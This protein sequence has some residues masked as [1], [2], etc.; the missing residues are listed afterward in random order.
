MIRLH[1]APQTRSMRTLWLLHELGL[2]FEVVERPFDK[3]LRAPDYLALS[4]AGRV[5]SLE[6]DGEILFETGAIA[7]Y[8]CERF[9]EAGLGVAPGDEGRAD[10]LIWL[11]FAE[12]LS[13]H[14]AA[15][16][17]QHIMLYE[18]A[19]RSPVVMKLE[20]ARLGKCY[21]ALEAR[22][23]GR[24]HLAAGRATA[25]DIGVAQA[26]YMAR[27]FA[28]I[29]DFPRLAAWYARMTARPAFAASLPGEG[30]RLYAKDFY[31]AWEG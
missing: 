26:I 10:W 27:H 30:A 29:E 15:L 23:E 18:D 6:I 19:M 31:P 17:Q 28:P 25:A 16:T 21:A 22:L 20:A 7:E 2:D 9:P 14:A 13:Q 4:P 11:H 8:L 5:P 24:D 3:S 12:T 1:H